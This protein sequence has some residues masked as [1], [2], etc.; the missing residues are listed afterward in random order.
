[1]DYFIIVE[2][3]KI[4][5]ESN[6]EVFKDF[7]DKIAK[8]FKEQLDGKYKKAFRKIIFAIYS[9]KQNYNEFKNILNL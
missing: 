8:L 6:K 9:E 2:S 4:S 7:E 5:Y 3:E 1:M